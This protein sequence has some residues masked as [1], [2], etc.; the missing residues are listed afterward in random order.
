MVLVTQVLHLEAWSFH[1]LPITSFKPSGIEM[2]SGSWVALFLYF[3]L[4]EQHLLVQDTHHPHENEATKALSAV[5]KKTTT[6]MK[7]A[8]ATRNVVH[9]HGFLPHSSA[10]HLVYS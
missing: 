3:L 1:H 2:H 9:H 6:M 10:S 4:L 7:K 8:K 5:K